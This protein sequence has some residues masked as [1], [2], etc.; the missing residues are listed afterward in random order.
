MEQFD[1]WVAAREAQTKSAPSPP[2]PAKNTVQ[3]PKY[4]TLTALLGM[5]QAETIDLSAEQYALIDA[6]ASGAIDPE[7]F[8]PRP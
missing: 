2:K 6:I 4:D 1:S 3:V 5:D 8:T 7:T